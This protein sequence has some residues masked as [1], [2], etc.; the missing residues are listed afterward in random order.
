M[1]NPRHRALSILH[2]D[3]PLE[4]EIF[5]HYMWPISPS[6]NRASRPG[7]GIRLKASTYLARLQRD[8]LAERRAAGEAA[9]YVLSSLGQRAL[10]QPGAR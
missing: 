6:W 1:G 2:P 8:G 7:R 9:G 10:A 5:A 3:Y 4:P